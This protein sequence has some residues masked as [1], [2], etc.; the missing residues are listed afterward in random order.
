ML[1]SDRR[2]IPERPERAQASLRPPTRWREGLAVLGLGLGVAAAARAGDLAAFAAD[3]TAATAVAV[4]VAVCSA[5]LIAAAGL[6][7]DR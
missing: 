1:R 6:I 7:A 5:M 3:H 4:A 2:W